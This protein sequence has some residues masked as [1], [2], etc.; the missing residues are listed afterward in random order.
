[1][2]LTFHKLVVKSNR[3]ARRKAVVEF[4]VDSG[5]V[6]SLAPTPA[7]KK[8]GLRPYRAVDFSLADGTKISRRVG[9]AYF[10]LDGRSGPSPVIFGE[11]DDQPLLG[12]TTLEALGLML[13]PF[14]RRLIPMR[15]MLA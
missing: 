11:E 8:L 6:Y 1:M 9:D 14:T 3:K 2:G 10:E 15:M 4:L 7:L 12:V 13:D 5:A